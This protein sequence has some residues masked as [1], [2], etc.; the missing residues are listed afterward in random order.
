MRVRDNSKVT[1]GIF[2]MTGKAFLEALAYILNIQYEIPNLF[3][4]RTKFEKYTEVDEVYINL[5]KMN[6]KSEQH[7]DKI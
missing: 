6:I 5:M 7:W 2:S 1:V 4:T 3:I